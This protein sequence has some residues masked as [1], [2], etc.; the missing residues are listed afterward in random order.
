LEFVAE[1]D[2]NIMGKFFVQHALKHLVGC[3]MPSQIANGWPGAIFFAILITTASITPKVVA[4]YSLKDLL[5]AA[6]TDKMQGEGVQK[7]RHSSLGHIGHTLDIIM[8][9]VQL[10]VS[11]SFIQGLHL[12]ELSGVRGGQQSAKPS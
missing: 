10:Y 6:T 2:L 11:T 4:G 7:V 12:P 1:L 5:E 9:A 3:L 8:S